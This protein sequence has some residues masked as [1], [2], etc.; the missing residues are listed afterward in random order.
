MYGVSLQRNSDRGRLCVVTVVKIAA[1]M[2]MWSR[3]TQ[4][5]RSKMTERL[6]RFMSVPAELNISCSPV[7]TEHCLAMPLRASGPTSAS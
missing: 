6:T 3:S 4:Y 7:A 2:S 5:D 1:M